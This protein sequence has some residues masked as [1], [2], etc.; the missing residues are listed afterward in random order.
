[1]PRDEFRVHTRLAEVYILRELTDAAKALLDSLGTRPIPDQPPSHIS[2]APALSKT[3]E[4]AYRR[5][6]RRPEQLP[7]PCTIHSAYPDNPD[8]LN[9]RR[10]AK[11]L[12]R[13]MEVDASLTTWRITNRY[14]AKPGKCL[15]VGHYNANT[16]IARSADSAQRQ[17]ASGGGAGTNYYTSRRYR[18]RRKRLL[19]IEDR[20]ALAAVGG[21]HLKPTEILGTYRLAAPNVQRV[22]LI[23]RRKIFFCAPTDGNEEIGDY[24]NAA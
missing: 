17:Y 9:R 11:L 23:S 10:D 7:G 4:Q 5:T 12:S 18:D 6:T 2:A 19:S 20:R 13:D 24:A 21:Y 3:Q 16:V 8:E 1:M 22:D 14:P 15:F